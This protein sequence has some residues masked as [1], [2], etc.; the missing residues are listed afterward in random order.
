MRARHIMSAVPV[1]VRQATPVTATRRLSPRAA[2]GRND[3]VH[4]H[5][6]GMKVGI[7]HSTPVTSISAC[8]VRLGVASATAENRRRRRAAAR[9]PLPHRRNY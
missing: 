7:C 6:C 8:D 4:D 3:H 2:S 5:E 1:F 9:P